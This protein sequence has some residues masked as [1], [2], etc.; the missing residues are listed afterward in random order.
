[1]PVVVGRH[2]VVTVEVD[3]GGVVGNVDGTGIVVGRAVGQ[4]GSL[5]FGLARLSGPILGAQRVLFVGRR[6]LASRPHHARAEGAATVAS[7]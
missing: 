2:A 6:V 4:A 7:V 3:G 1:M 5:P